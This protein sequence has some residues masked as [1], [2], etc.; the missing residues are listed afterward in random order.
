MDP[1][2]VS[3]SD[4]HDVDIDRILHR[5]GALSRSLR[6]GSDGTMKVVALL[7]LETSL[8]TR[9]GFATAAARLGWQPIEVL[10]LRQSPTSMTESFEDTLR[11]VSGMAEIV[12]SRPARPIGREMISK[13][14]VS[15]F[16][17]A[18]DT[19]PSAEHPTQA[20]IDLYAIEKAL[21]PIS[22]LRLAIC[23]DL[24][25]RAVRSLVHL[26]ARR[27]PARL[28]IIAA[29]SHR[30]VECIPQPLAAISDYRVLPELDDIDVLYVA[31]IPHAS[32]PLDERAR[33]TVTTEALSR[34]PQ[35]SIVLSPMPIID[36]IDP[37]ARSD[38][39]MRMFW[40]SDQALFVRM[41]L[42][43]EIVHH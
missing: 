31:G 3:A 2:L 22:G 27:R 4:L 29:P 33:L 43:E 41:A 5:A 36:E 34:L 12:V 37:A 30:A 6:V 40:Q 16:I 35:R 18:G 25:M 13:H 7:F 9:V 32:L 21:G 28:S 11:T 17:N 38:Q 39:R 1:L 42:L 19:G 20:L 14:V 10:E 15:A 26:L 8:R 23:G 24:R